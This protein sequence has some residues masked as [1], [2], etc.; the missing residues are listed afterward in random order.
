MVFV[1]TPIRP[2]GDR[3]IG[4]R[5]CLRRKSLRDRMPCKPGT[6]PA[7]K[8]RQKGLKHVLAQRPDGIVIPDIRGFRRAP[9]SHQ[10]VG[11]GERVFA[12]LQRPL[13]KAKA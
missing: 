11:A 3:G 4:V 8:R 12:R 9:A 5:A 10:A 13:R 6:L 1:S 2:P 7:A